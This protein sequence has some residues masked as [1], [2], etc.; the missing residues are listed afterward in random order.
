MNKANR[1][2]HLTLGR[3]DKEGNEIVRRAM[4]I[5]KYSHMREPGGDET[6]RKV[7]FT[8]RHEV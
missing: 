3:D 2:S 5:I 6:V 1:V 7:K 8:F 4:R